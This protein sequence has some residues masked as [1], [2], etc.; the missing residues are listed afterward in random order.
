MIA[1]AWAGPVGEGRRP[2]AERRRLRGFSEL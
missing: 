1:S 2:F